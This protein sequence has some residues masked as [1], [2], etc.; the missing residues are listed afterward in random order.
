MSR[1]TDYAKFW[2]PKLQSTISFYLQYIFCL[3]HAQLNKAF[4]VNIAGYQSNFKS[5]CQRI[6]D[7]IQLLI[8]SIENHVAT[9][10]RCGTRNRNIKLILYLLLDHV[11]ILR[12]R[13]DSVTISSLIFLRDHV[14]NAINMRQKPL[15]FF[16]LIDIMTICTVTEAQFCQNFSKQTGIIN[17]NTLFLQ[18]LTE[19]QIQTL[20]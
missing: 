19:P 17:L 2:N 6:E 20:H 5:K 1:C 8:Q 16:Q 13:L 3:L 4:E 9:I 12:D 18:G 10:S 7:F 11:D 14:E 15:K